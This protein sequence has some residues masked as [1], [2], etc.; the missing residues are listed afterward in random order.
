MLNIEMPELTGFELCRKLR[1]LPGYEQTPVIYV[2]S[3]ADFEHRV[4]SIDVGA[5]DLI[6][7]PIFPMEL[8]VK[9]ILHL[10]R[11]KLAQ[12]VGA[13]AVSSTSAA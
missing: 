5:H 8:A 7:K 11:A 12:P 10:I 13:E 1:E 3:H 4:R 6:A 2:T 9:A